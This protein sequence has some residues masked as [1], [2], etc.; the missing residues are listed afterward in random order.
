MNLEW[1]AGAS[2]RL[3]EPLEVH[4]DLPI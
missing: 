2:S 4:L 1:D 3:I